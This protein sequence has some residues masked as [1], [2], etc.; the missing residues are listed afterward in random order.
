MESL[1]PAPPRPHDRRVDRPD[2]RCRGD[3]PVRVRRRRLAVRRDHP[4][5]TAWPVGPDRTRRGARRARRL[6]DDRRRALSRA[7]WAHRRRRRRCSSSP[8]RTASMPSS[9]DRSTATLLAEFDDLGIVSVERADGRPGDRDRVRD[10]VRV[11]LA[12]HA[13]ASRPSHR[14]ALA[15]RR[16]VG[17]CVAA[18][19][20]PAGRV[21]VDRRHDDRPVPRAPQ[22]RGPRARAPGDPHRLR[23]VRDRRDAGVVAHDRGLVRDGWHVRDRPAARRVRAR[24]GVASRRASREQAERVRRLRLGSRLD[25]LDGARRHAIVWRSSV[26]RTAGSSSVRRSPSAPICAGPCGVRCRCST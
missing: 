18:D 21:R 14:R 23:R 24:R 16:T 17:R 19:D 5:R 11:R 1:R 26:G 9:G 13:L 6:G 2:R 15:T 10:H 3:H 4:R 12:G 25:G 7:R 8:A 22:R 20:R